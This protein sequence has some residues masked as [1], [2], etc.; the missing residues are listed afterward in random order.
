MPGMPGFGSD[1][2][3][4]EIDAAVAYLRTLVL[5]GAPGFV[6]APETGGEE[7]A[8]SVDQPEPAATEEVSEMAEAPVGEEAAPAETS[9]DPALL[10]VTG[11]VTNGTEGGALPEG[12]SITLH[13]FDPPEFTETTLI[14]TVADDGTYLF[15]DV[16]YE[17]GRVYLLSLEYDDVFFSSTVYE[18]TEPG[19]PALTTA[20]QVF[21]TTDDPSVLTFEAG[22]MR[23]TFTHFGME[24]AQVLSLTNASDRLFLTDEFYNENQRVALRIPLPPGAGGVGFE[25]GMQG[26]RFFTSADES[27]VID[28]QPVRPGRD[29][30]FFSYFIPYEDGAII[31]QEMT[32]PF[33]GPFHLLIESDQV[34]V[35]SALFA[36]AGERVDMGGAAFDAYVAELTL[37]TGEILNFTL[38]GT[39]DAVSAL[40]DAQQPTSQN[41]PP[42]VI[43]LIVVGV[44]LVGAAGFMFLLRQGSGGAADN[45][46][47]RINDLLEAIADLDNQHDRGEINHDVY[48]RTRAKLKAELADLMKDEG[49]DA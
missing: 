20:L 28:T 34:A 25:P 9:D 5:D 6:A 14:G 23:V 46:D 37:A 43:V 47:A 16:P 10:T 27:V 36:S 49:P 26:T 15:L 33:V 38:S 29:D 44:V 3:A 30:I 22:V 24:V 13:M 45:L 21:E 7:A 4:G 35:E 11:Q 1:L 18:V 32:Y 12:A 40:R 39:P 17:T 42:A 2:T 8:A 41:L 48:Q 31:E 19:S